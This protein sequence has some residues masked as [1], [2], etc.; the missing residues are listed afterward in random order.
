[1]VALPCNHRF[2]ARGLNQDKDAG[3]V[4]ADLKPEPFGSHPSGIRTPFW[5]KLQITSSNSAIST[6]LASVFSRLATLTR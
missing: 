3:E 6:S 1:V 5:I 2:S 4:T